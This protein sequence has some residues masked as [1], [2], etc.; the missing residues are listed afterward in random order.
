MPLCPKN[1]Q[2][3]GSKNLVKGSHWIV[4]PGV[5]GSNPLV[6]PLLDK[7][8]RGSTRRPFF[9][10]GDDM[11]YRRS[12]QRRAPT[13]GWSGSGSPQPSGSARQSEAQPR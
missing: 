2:S 6:H 4:V 10:G 12:F 13:A 1:S 8:R 9:H 3:K 7:G 11:E 5:G